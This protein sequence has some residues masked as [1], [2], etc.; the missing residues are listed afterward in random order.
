L[1]LHLE[2]L[3]RFAE[4]RSTLDGV[5]EPILCREASSESLNIPPLA[6]LE[7]VFNL[8]NF[9]VVVVDSRRLKS[10]D[11]L[12]QLD[13]LCRKHDV[14]LVQLYSMGLVGGYRISVREHCVLETHRKDIPIIQSLRLHPW[15]LA[16]NPELVK[17]AF[18]KQF[19]ILEIGPENLQDREG[20]PAH[21]ADLE[22]LHAQVPYPVILIRAFWRAAAKCSGNDCS[23]S[24]PR[25]GTYVPAPVSPTALIEE[26][27]AMRW[28]KL[29]TAE[30]SEGNFDEAV[31]FAKQM[32]RGFS[33]RMSNALF[34]VNLAVTTGLEPR[35]IEVLRET[36]S[37]PKSTQEIIDE[38]LAVPVVE[39]SMTASCPPA[40]RLTHPF[41]VVAR[42]IGRLQQIT[43]GRFSP[44]PDVPDMESSTENYVAL[45]SVYR[46]LGSRDA[47]L[48]QDAISAELKSVGRDES[49]E[50]FILRAAK[51]WGLTSDTLLKHVLTNF[52]GM[53]VFR[54][55]S[56]EEEFGPTL[57]AMHTSSL[58]EYV[59]DTRSE[60]HGTDMESLPLNTDW[61]IA[62]RACLEFQTRHGHLPGAPAYQRPQ[63]EPMTQRA[64]SS[65][66]PDY[67][68]ESDN[69]WES[70]LC[71]LREIHE[72][73]HNRIFGISSVAAT[74]EDVMPDGS[75]VADSE[76]P[77]PNPRP[78]CS[79]ELCRQGCREIHTMASIVGSLSADV[80]IKLI[81]RQYSIPNNCVIYNGIHG[82][83]SVFEV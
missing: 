19:D 39:D 21:V 74:G 57:D 13:K 33:D 7:E 58:R 27:N 6:S 76:N 71:E 83:G 47:A 45:K 26:I 43:Q 66:N 3:K 38:S 15:L 44:L 2:G 10:L 72:S 1:E 46:E 73:I 61:Y 31:A 22:Q 4:G 28:R 36:V 34:G 41:W 64:E 16:Q 77:A 82:V 56:L 81:L 35:L 5:P 12:I 65:T 23:T 25:D 49:V 11:S 17:F 29:T 8:K 62:M 18:S 20:M 63:D 42:S 68:W 9:N 40:D 69:S 78:E 70:D 30:P 52:T 75:V 53:R 37:L 60:L 54:T 55:R 50:D 79:V 32:M 67:D 51:H 59:M 14:A 48:L 80:V 24:Y